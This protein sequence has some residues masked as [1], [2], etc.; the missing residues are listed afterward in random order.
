M[1]IFKPIQI[2]ADIATYNWL[3]ITDKYW[4]NA[5]N[6]FIYDTIKIGLLLIV[7]NYVMAVTRYYFPMEKVR[8][9]L[10]KR[11]WYG[12]D[13]L[14]A[15]ILGIITP[16]CSCSSIPLFIGFVSAGIPLGVTLSFLIASPLVNEASLFLFPTMFGIKMTIIYNLIGITVA[17][18]GGMV[19][20]RLK[21]ERFINPN[22]LKFKS[23]Q[24]IEEEIEKKNNN[25]ITLKKK[26]IYWWKDGM[27]ISTSLF[28]YILIGVGVG[29]L[30][31][32]F[33]PQT[34]I[35]GH[36][37][38]RHWWTVPLATIL[39]APIYANSISVIPVIEALTEKGV[40]L[41]TSLA[42]MTS[43]VTLSI[44]SVLILK[45]IMRWQ[46]LLAFLSITSIGIMAI[47]YFFNWMY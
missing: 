30:I 17:I 18:L 12:F 21:M 9:I 5:I 25:K 40:P 24:E 45:K 2:L 39:G 42:F 37:S 43:A 22:F 16:F 31:H 11:R 15:A 14:M 26:M 47:G 27:Q 13:Y 4:G 10:T 3:N 46:L 34:F 32:G 23:R 19:I 1:D 29:A 44:P 6:F 7:I 8:D 38:S 41:G 35:E 33:I 28:P 36:L 20:Q